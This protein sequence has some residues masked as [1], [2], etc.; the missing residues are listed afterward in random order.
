MRIGGL[1]EPPAENVST[2]STASLLGFYTTTDAL[3]RLQLDFSVATGSY[4]GIA[5]VIITQ[6]VPEPSTFLIWSLGL[7]GLAWYARRR[8]TRYVNGTG[9]ILAI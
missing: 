2:A 6:A 8:R 3:G 1:G 5:G 4:A 9:L 7:L